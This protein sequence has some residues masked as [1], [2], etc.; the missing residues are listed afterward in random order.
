[1]YFDYKLG[2]ILKGL[3]VCDLMGNIVF[4]SEFFIGFMLDVII[5]EKSGF[6][7]FLY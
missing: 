1:M 7:K 3:I 2:I 4:V 6:C 5:I